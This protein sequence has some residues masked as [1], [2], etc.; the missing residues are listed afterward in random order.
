MMQK[1]RQMPGSVILHTLE[2]PH[3]RSSKL[4][5]CVSSLFSEID[6]ETGMK[7]VYWR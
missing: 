5:V 6:I 3:L 2:E 7:E 4:S 1:E